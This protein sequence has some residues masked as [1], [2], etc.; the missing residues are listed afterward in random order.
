MLEPVAMR[1]APPPLRGGAAAGAAA[2]AAAAE[3]A[4]SLG[5]R[6][7]SL[8]A[9]PSLAGA[10]PGGATTAAKSLPGEVSG[11]RLTPGGPGGRWPSGNQREGAAPRYTSLGASEALQDPGA[12]SAVA[13]A[14]PEHED[15]AVAATTPAP[16][17][18]AWGQVANGG[19]RPAAPGAPLGAAW[20]VRNPTAAAVAAAAAAAAT[21]AQV[22]LQPSSQQLALALGLTGAFAAGY[23]DLSQRPA[24]VPAEAPELQAS[25]ELPRQGGLAAPPPARSQSSSSLLQIAA[26]PVAAAQFQGGHWR[27]AC[28]AFSASACEASS[29]SCCGAGFCPPQLARGSGPATGAAGTRATAFIGGTGT[30]AVP[31]A[32]AAPF[33]P[34]SVGGCGGCCGATS[35][36]EASFAASVDAAFPGGDRESDRFNAWLHRGPVSSPTPSAA[37]GSQAIFG[38]AATTAAAAAALSMTSV[39]Q[40]S[41]G[42]CLAMLPASADRCTVPWPPPPLPPMP[43]ELRTRLESLEV[44]RESQ[45]LAA[46]AADR[47][48]AQLEAELVAAQA[49]VGRAAGLEVQLR[50]FHIEKQELSLRHSDLVSESERLRRD[51]RE[52][53]AKHVAERELHAETRKQHQDLLSSFERQ[54]GDRQELQDA[55]RQRREALELECDRLKQELSSFRDAEHRQRSHESSEVVRLREEVSRLEVVLTEAREEVRREKEECSRLR[56]RDADLERQAT[57]MEGELTSVRNEMHALATSRD[58]ELRFLRTELAR[59]AEV[60]E[61]RRAAEEELRR[62]LVLEQEQTKVHVLE[63]DRL[64]VERD[65][66]QA[67]A[68]LQ[69]DRIQ[70]SGSMSE[71]QR[72]EMAK[73]AF[74]LQSASLMSSRRDSRNTASDNLSLCQVDLTEEMDS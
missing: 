35:A 29:S 25:R 36:A 54:Q 20:D 33:P 70:L 42:G 12:A 38:S 34:W 58:E 49:S 26:E 55:E 48:V 6:P 65:A 63:I 50:D 23:S 1:E 31:A 43:L 67:R 57:Q 10:A 69:M 51:L 74:A 66:L 47:R 2:A 41:P 68:K 44:L 72:D 22:P 17:P 39:A 62:I 60:L 45:T 16:G 11:L 59:M 24:P 61:E 46:A 56:M 13:L 71:A 4:A 30:K 64:K 15:V 9:K 73:Q 3:L 8:A 53:Q 28:D 21:Q 14:E 7:A 37:A 27:G 32:S 52:A 5:S 40:G 18:G 19:G